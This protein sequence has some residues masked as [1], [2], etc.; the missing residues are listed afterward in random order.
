M[1]DTLDSAREEQPP[2]EE[3][4]RTR[5]PLPIV[6]GV[7]LGLVLS[8]FLARYFFGDSSPE[9]TVEAFQQ[10]Q[11]RWRDAN[12]KDYRVEVEVVSRQKERY[13]VEV[14]GGEPQQAWRNGQPLKQMRIFDTWSVPGMF[15]T[16]ADDLRLSEPHQQGNT[17]EIAKQLYLR[18]TFDDATGAPVRYHRVQWGSHLDIVW[19][20]TKLEQIHDDGATQTLI[21][22]PA[23]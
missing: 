19:Q 12:I 11:T 3:A 21:P 18:C 6:V 16:I 4:Q 20:I 1:S 10:A 8:I 7:L 23:P 13:T 5:F 15:A 2:H 9:L 14:R 22:P 17:G